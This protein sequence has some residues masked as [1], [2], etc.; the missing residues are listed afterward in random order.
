MSSYYSAVSGSIELED[1]PPEVR[2]GNTE[3]IG[4]A[5][6]LYREILDGKGGFEDLVKKPFLE[7]QFNSELVRDVIRKALRDSG[8]RYRDA[9]MRLRIP[10]RRYALILQFL[11][12]NNC[13]L[14]FRPFR[15]NRLGPIS[16]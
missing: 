3:K 16:E 8:G 11:K 1:L 6:R 14:D 2:K 15:N 5:E 4:L 10:D 13:Y 9:F 7:R 12:R